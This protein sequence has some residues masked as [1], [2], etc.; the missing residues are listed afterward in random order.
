[1]YLVFIF[2]ICFYILYQ[3][4]N[5]Y[6]L[7]SLWIYFFSHNFQF[8]RILFYPLIALIAVCFYGCNIYT[9]S[10]NILDIFFLNLFPELFISSGASFISL[11]WF[12]SLIFCFP[13]VSRDPQ[14][15]IPVYKWGTRLPGVCNQHEFLLQLC[16][17]VSP[18]SPPLNGRSEAVRCELWRGDYWQASL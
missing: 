18:L 9:M 17:S 6:F 4:T 14:L 7:K 12:F 13:Q 10:L 3:F 1:M 16:S 2:S 11:A 8:L 5:M 15:S